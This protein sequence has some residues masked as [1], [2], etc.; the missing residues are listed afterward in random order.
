MGRVGDDAG[1]PPDFIAA[2]HTG[3]LLRGLYHP[4]LGIGIEFLSDQLFEGRSDRSGLRRVDVGD[5]TQVLAIPPEDVIADRLGQHAAASGND[6]TQ[7][8]LAQMVYALA[9]NIDAG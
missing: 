1:F 8:V 7:L 5:G 4:S 6:R 2:L 9:G 3:Y